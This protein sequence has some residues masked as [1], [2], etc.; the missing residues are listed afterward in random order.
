M[1][2]RKKIKRKKKGTG[3]NPT[4]KKTEPYFGKRVQSAVVLHQ[5]ITAN[6]VKLSNLL[7][8]RSNEL[9]IDRF[10]K[11]HIKNSNLTYDEAFKKLLPVNHNDYSVEVCKTE[12]KDMRHKQ[13]HIYQ[14]TIQPAFDKLVENLIFIHNFMSLHDSYE[15]LK[16]DC[17]SFLYQALPKFDESKGARAFSYFNVIAKNFLII[18][19]K[20]RVAKIKRNISLDD[21]DSM[22]TEET[23]ALIEYYTIPSPDDLMAEHQYIFEIYDLLELIKKRLKNDAEVKCVCAIEDIFKTLDDLELLNKRAVFQYIRDHS[24]LSAKQLTTTMSV[25]KRYYKDAKKEYL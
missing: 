21:P 11:N 5:E 16:A 12:I 4:G 1:I 13:D 14:T 10:V 22:G 17:V 8:V 7:E 20:S 24:G 23:D 18:K 19:S 3:S 6:I 25:I 2:K 15:D 9:T